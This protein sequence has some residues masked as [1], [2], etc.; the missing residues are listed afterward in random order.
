MAKFTPS[1]R[2]GIQPERYSW[3]II[4][5]AVA[6]ES[7]STHVMTTGRQA[8]VGSGTAAVVT[9]VHE[10]VRWRR[11]CRRRRRNVA[12]RRLV[13]AAAPVRHGRRRF[14]GPLWRCFRVVGG[15][16]NIFDSYQLLVI[17]VI[18]VDALMRHR[19]RH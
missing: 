5:P 4:A 9:Y 8:E 16:Y 13:A 11:R 12:G 3:R 6:A 15:R 7:S 14:S 10:R 19:Y 18:V 2:Y 17:I 1:H